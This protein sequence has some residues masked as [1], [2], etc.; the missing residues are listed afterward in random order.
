[1]GLRKVTPLLDSRFDTI[2]SRP[3]QCPTKSPPPPP[4]PLPPPPAFPPLQPGEALHPSYGFWTLV[5]TQ[6]GPDGSSDFNR[7]DF[8][9]RMAPHLGVPPEDVVLNCSTATHPQHLPEPQSQAQ[10]QGIAQLSDELGVNV[11]YISDIYHSFCV[12]PAP[13]PSPPPPSRPPLPPPPAQPPQDVWT[14]AQ[15]YA[16]LS[17]TSISHIRLREGR[18]YV[19]QGAE[20]NAAIEKLCTPP[21]QSL[22]IEGVA[23]TGSSQPH[24]QVMSSAGQLDISCLVRLINL[25]M[26]VAQAVRVRTHGT[27]VLSGQARIDGELDVQGVVRYEMPAPLGTFVPTGIVRQCSEV[28][29][30]D[31]ATAV[32]EL[33]GPSSLPQP[34]MPGYIGNSTELAAQRT[35]A[36]ALHCAQGHYCPQGSAFPTPCPPGSFSAATQAASADTCSICPPGTACTAGSIAPTP[37][38]PGT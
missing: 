25:H 29:C 27:L 14:A 13:P 22:A 8:R 10:R 9:R 37:C 20:A 15:L 4:P 38:Q 5:L 36:C 26:S 7:T 21:R 31:G 17:D 16:A 3:G 1:M 19:L 33:S 23:S 35:P 2:V 32:V 6:L 18:D 24:V 12:T 30:A 28:Q 34:C 11:K